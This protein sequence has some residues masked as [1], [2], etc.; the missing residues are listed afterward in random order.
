M[1]F[2]P[3]NYPERL[4]ILC[5]EPAG[6]PETNWHYGIWDEGVWGEI[7]IPACIDPNVCREHA[8]RVTWDMP[9]RR[10]WMDKYSNPHKRIGAKYN[11]TCDN[12]R[13]PEV[14]LIEF[15]FQWLVIRLGV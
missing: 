4:S 12:D 6:Y 15:C 10:E 7:E 14:I 13:K 2:P 3:G 8:P 9:V 5:S 1:L 11:Y